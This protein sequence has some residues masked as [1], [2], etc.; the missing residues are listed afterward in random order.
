MIKIQKIYCKKP[1]NYIFN[2]QKSLCKKR[3]RALCLI[4]GMDLIV[5]VCS[6]KAE[7]LG[8]LVSI[9]GLRGI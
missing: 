5:A 6:L 8:C 4:Y 9:L 3:K 2:M 1:K 7:Y